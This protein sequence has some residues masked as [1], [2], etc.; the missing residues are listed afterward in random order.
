MTEV[1]SSSTPEGPESPLGQASGL[2]AGQT[3]KPT[4]QLAASV[5]RRGA[6]ALLWLLALLAVLGSGLLGFVFLQQRQA[7]ETLAG[8]AYTLQQRSAAF[9]QRLADAEAERTRLAQQLQ[10]VLDA[11]GDSAQQTD[12]TALREQLAALR[13]DLA[14]QAASSNQD[15]TLV[16][17]G[18]LLRLAQQQATLGRNVDAAISLYMSAASALQQHNDPALQPA[19][20]ALQLE[21]DA[22]HAVQLPDIQGIYLQLGELQQQLATLAVQSEGEAPLQFVA[23]DVGALPATASWWEQIKYTISRYFVVTRRDVPVLAQL[24]PQQAEQVRQAIALQLETARLAL[25]QGDVRVYQA[26]LQSAAEGI[27]QQLQ[28]E[29]KAALLASLQRLHEADIVAVIPSL[30]QAL[31]ALELV[32]TGIRLG[33]NAPAQDS[34]VLVLDRETLTSDSEALPIDGDTPATDSEAAP[35]PGNEAVT[36]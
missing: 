19:L 27:T 18:S 23:P 34:E 31:Q 22:L 33:G 32:G 9:E 17:A 15:Q 26:A 6:P 36:P 35:S 29:S 5:S 7:M 14:A 12:V 2:A 4:A 8:D 20:A 11:S 21:L 10:T 13:Q 3:A 25:L 24:S 30:G 28:G 1:N 16:E